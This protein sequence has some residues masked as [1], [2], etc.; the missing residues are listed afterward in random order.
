[1]EGGEGCDWRSV[2]RMVKEMGV[3]S[4]MEMGFSGEG[5]GM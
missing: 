5:I 1:M 3:K 2:M 4:G